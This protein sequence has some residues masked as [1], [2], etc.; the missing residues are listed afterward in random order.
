M[1]FLVAYAFGCELWAPWS[2][3]FGRW[4]IMQLS[5]TFMNIWQIPCALAPNF[6]TMV[7]GRFLGGISLAGGSVTLGMTA[8]MWE[9]D[10]QGFAV[11]YV[12]LSSVGGTT[13]GPFFGG[14]MEQWLHWRWNFWIQLIFGGV[15]QIMHLLLVPG[16]EAPS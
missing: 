14:M 6:G 16:S 8:D 10:D 5:L 3:E 4:P 13:I 2:E 12:V 1:I 11:A 7:V 9:A 15:T